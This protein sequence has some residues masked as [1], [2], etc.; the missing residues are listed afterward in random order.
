MRQMLEGFVGLPMVLNDA[1]LFLL[2]YANAYKLCA[3]D[4]PQSGRLRYKKD[5]S[6]SRGC[7]PVSLRE[8]AGG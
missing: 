3:G 2:I 7:M 1:D 8:R 4:A 5:Y 6:D